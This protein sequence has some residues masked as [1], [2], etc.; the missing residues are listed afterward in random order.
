MLLVRRVRRVSGESVKLLFSVAVLLNALLIFWVELFFAKR[1]LPAMGGSPAVWN[2]SLM[3][4]QVVILAGYGYVLLID[5]L[6]PRRQVTLHSALVLLAVGLLPWSLFLWSGP[7]GDA[8]ILWLLTLLLLSLGPPFFVLSTG[9]PLLQRWFSHTTHRERGDPYFLYAASNAGSFLALAAYPLLIEPFLSLEDQETVWKASF[10]GVGGLVLLAGLAMV[11]GGGRREEAHPVAPSSRIA[12]TRRGRWV[13]L[14]FV[15]SSLLLGVT[16]HITS[17]I[18]PV[19]LLWIVPLGLYLLTFIVAFGTKLGGAIAGR[20]G[21]VIAGGAIT[22]APGD[23]TEGRAI[24]GREGTDAAIR[25]LRPSSA[26][27]SSRWIRTAGTVLIVVLGGVLLWR[28]RAEAN[29]LL[30]LG[31]LVILTAAGLVC[32]GRLARDRPAP[33]R[34]AEYYLWIAFGGA[35]GGVFNTLLAPNLFED[36]LEYPLVLALFAF[37]ASARGGKS[38]D[39]V[40]IGDFVLGLVPGALALTLASVALRW[41]MEPRVL[42]PI[43]GIACLAVA[44]RPVR[45]GLGVAGLVLVG[46][47]LPVESG[48]VIFRERTF[49]GIHRIYQDEAHHWLA[50]GTTVHGG[51]N[52]LEPGVP[53]TYYHPDGPAGS[54]LSAFQGTGETS[55]GVRIAA[56]GLGTGSLMAYAREGEWWDLFE[57]D[58]TVARIAEDP[59]YFTFLH[60]ARAEYEIVLGDARLSMEGRGGLYDFIVVD[61]FSSD[62]IPVHLLTREAIQLYRGQLRPGGWIAFHTSNRYADFSSVLANLASETALFAF[63]GT[64]EI[65]DSLVGRYPSRWV[66]LA[67]DSADP[68]IDL[69]L[70]DSRWQPLPSGEGR[71]WTDGYS[72]ILEVLRPAAGR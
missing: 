26:L 64:D 70:E 39:R 46:F 34:L 33:A 40:R 22:G 59:A 63:E 5:R 47:N 71:V 29:W 69:L 56:V 42:L 45:F 24:S 37:L 50:H 15:P 2:T 3:F 49:Y 51:E 38:V 20:E 12:P 27:G 1:L 55:E 68:R 16:T 53:L 32:H 7:P 66:L 35:L 54:L 41:G 61:A 65:G 8:P 13:L 62:A 57:L 52:L 72:S 36:P 23:G 30:I 60:S 58:P 67:E 10:V 44:G 43:A 48:R 25:P 28:F 21:D 4:Y 18:A 6:S 9:A 11:R 19:P 17:E 31:D 14:A